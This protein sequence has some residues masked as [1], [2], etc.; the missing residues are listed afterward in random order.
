MY[1]YSPTVDCDGGLRRWLTEVRENPINPSVTQERRC[2]V[3]SGGS[4]RPNETGKSKRTCQSTEKQTVTRRTRRG[5]KDAG[6]AWSGCSHLFPPRNIRLLNKLW[7]HGLW[8]LPI[9]SWNCRQCPF[10]DLPNDLCDGI[11]L[12]TVSWA[13]LLRSLCKAIVAIK[14]FIHFF[15]L[16]FTAAP[17]TGTQSLFTSDAS[18]CLDQ[19]PSSNRP[20]LFNFVLPVFMLLVSPLQSS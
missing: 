10:I 19:N 20:L 8:T 17:R 6:I 1:L 2:R 7:T 14:G 13:F 3:F 11:R 12:L 18:A 9:C 16:L 5:A 4:D 15:G